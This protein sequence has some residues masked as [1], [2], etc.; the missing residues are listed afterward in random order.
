MWELVLVC[1]RGLGLA[2]RGSGHQG[3]QGGNAAR[4]HGG[5]FSMAFDRMTDVGRQGLV[6]AVVVLA[7]PVATRAHADD[8][9]MD[10]QWPTL[11]HYHE[12]SD[13]DQIADHLSEIGNVVGDHMNVLS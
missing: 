6:L 7:A 1:L 11:P 12:T 4:F 13:S 2:S 10:K 5:T 8:M 3:E 9:P